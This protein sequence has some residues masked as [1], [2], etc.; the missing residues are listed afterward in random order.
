ML[1]EAAK[2]RIRYRDLALADVTRRV[3][4]RI[5]RQRPAECGA[6]VRHRGLLVDDRE[7]RFEVMIDGLAGDEKPHDLRRS[8]EDQVDP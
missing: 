4:D 3:P 6:L 2:V 8:F 5:E 7:G 1:G